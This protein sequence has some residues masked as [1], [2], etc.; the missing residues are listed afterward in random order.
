MPGRLTALSPSPRSAYYVSVRERGFTFVEILFAI[1]VLGIGF[2]MIAAIFPVGLQQTKLTM[3]E[4]TGAA[5]SRAMSARLQQIAQSLVQYDTLISSG[6][7]SIPETFDAHGQAPVVTP[8]THYRGTVRTL[9][10]PRSFP[11][12][13]TINSVAL[14][15][16]QILRRRYGQ[17]TAMANDLIN[18]SDPRNAS[19]VLY[20]R[21]A[22]SGLN[23]AGNPAFFGDSTAQILVI[24]AQSAN[25]PTYGP[26][27]V[28]VDGPITY[29]T[30]QAIFNLEA[31]PVAV[32]VV[33]DPTEG[34]YVAS[35]FSVRQLDNTGGDASLTRGGYP[36]GVS[37]SGNQ[38]D[39]V[40]DAAVDAVDTGCFV[41]ISDD[42]IQ[43]AGGMAGQLNG[44][45]FRL[46]SRRTDL[47][48]LT[49]D[50][51][52]G[53]GFTA[54]GGLDGK[55]N[56][57]STPSTDD[58]VAIGVDDKADTKLRSGITYG[59]G[60]SVVHPFNA[61]MP[62]PTSNPDGTGVSVYGS[63]EKQGAVALVLGKGFS[64]ASITPPGTTT[65]FSSYAGAVQ[66]VSLYTTFVTVPNQ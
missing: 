38:W 62:K 28:S 24:N 3:D 16:V 29:A 35:F 21:D 61:Q 48:G 26:A 6:V 14:T 18:P 50:L 45:T 12:A 39:A 63:P 32:Q 13:A 31:R 44:R 66:D 8:I 4:T 47:A 20:K 40:L 59:A 58:L 23:T 49:Y 46:G 54:D 60:A 51:V 30:K 33:Y 25:Q 36:V 37:P 5:G 57:T 34:N 19:V 55:L 2:I 1:A 9:N 22:V 43:A 42:R 27:D 17:W 15:P 10:D 7:A 11:D 53:Y 65:N 64:T 56:S 41:V 52:P